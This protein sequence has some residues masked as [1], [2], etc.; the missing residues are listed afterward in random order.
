MIRLFNPL[1]AQT[2][3]QANCA[4]QANG[5]A[6]P[7]HLR[8]SVAKIEVSSSLIGINPGKL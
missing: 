4:K 5:K 6:A 7:L 2:A 8:P 3:G 1:G